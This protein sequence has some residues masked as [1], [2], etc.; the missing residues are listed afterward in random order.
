MVPIEITFNDN[1]RRG[2]GRGRGGRGGRGGERGGGRS[3]RG[4]GGFGQ[5]GS[6][7]RGG[8]RGGGFRRES[9]EAAPNMQDEND[10]PSLVKPAAS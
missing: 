8:G 4:R 6:S 7:P 5:G 9:G 10:F 3:P 1:P 2:G